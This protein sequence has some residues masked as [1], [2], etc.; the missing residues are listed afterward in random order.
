MLE[1]I[2]NPQTPEMVK[3]SLFMGVAAIALIFAVAGPLVRWADNWDRQTRRGQPDPDS[4][5]N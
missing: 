5:T 2:L 1:A 4:P 3:F